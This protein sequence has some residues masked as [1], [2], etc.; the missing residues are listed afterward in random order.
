[1]LRRPSSTLV[2][3]EGKKGSDNVADIRVLRADIFCIVIQQ[4]APAK[5]PRAGKILRAMPQAKSVHLHGRN[6]KHIRF[7]LRKSV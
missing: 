1:L 4:E 6:Q 7:E 5:L 2:S 3:K